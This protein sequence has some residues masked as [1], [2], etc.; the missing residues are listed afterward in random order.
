MVEDK[1]WGFFALLDSNCKAPQPRVDT[2][3]EELFRRH[4][5]DPSIRIA[6]TDPGN[7]GKKRKKKKARRSRFLGFTCKHYVHDVT[8]D[9]SLFLR[10]NMEAS[11]PDTV[12]MFKRS[13]APLAVEI[14]GAGSSKKKKRATVTG[15]FH[16]TLNSLIKNLQATGTC[17][18]HHRISSFYRSGLPI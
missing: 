10:K 6:T 15:V 13:H 8:Y 14:G 11:H 12:K 17:I 16:K 3:L 5:E 1:K 2:F 7:E 4:S 9:A 18:F